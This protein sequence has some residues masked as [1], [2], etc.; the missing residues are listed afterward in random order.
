MLCTEVKLLPRPNRTIGINFSQQPSIE[1]KLSPETHAA[2]ES[3]YADLQT[4]PDVSPPFVRT[5]QVLHYLL[6]SVPPSQD[7]LLQNYPNPFNPE[8]WIPFQLASEAD[9][10]IKIFDVNGSLVR[11]LALGHLDAGFY[12]NPAEAAYWDGNNQRGEPVASGVYFYTIF[13]AVIQ[14]CSD[15]DNRGNNPP[16]ISRI[17]NCKQ[18]ICN[19]PFYLFYVRMVKHRNTKRRGDRTK[20]HGI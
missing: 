12:V 16:P 9:V 5:R 6:T 13:N 7:L 8:T 3:I 1:R 10:T 17:V 14:K 20:Y 19:V 4:N 11:K 15:Y 18:R 2:L